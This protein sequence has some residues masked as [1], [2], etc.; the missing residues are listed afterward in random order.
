MTRI[1][2]CFVAMLVS[3]CASSPSIQF[4]ALPA[5]TAA[6]SAVQP[7][8]APL[9]ISVDL[10]AI[11]ELVDRPQMVSRTGGSRVDV[12][13]FHQWAEPLKYAIPRAVSRELAAQLGAGYLVEAGGASGIPAHA[14]V[15]L[16]VQQFD[17]L[18]HQRVLV[19]AVWRIVRRSGDPTI[20][21]SK[22]E[23]A[24]TGAAYTGVA[25]AYG[26]ALATVAK[27][28]A[29]ALVNPGTPAAAKP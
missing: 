8:S 19:D 20:G 12:A 4:Y 29:A 1:A 21:R 9:T 11:P 17:T 10:S 26:R 22:V 23:E 13:E 27:D 25:E 5:T 7:I 2:A 14:R 15:M 16:D 6:P 28:I 18:D 3:A 24:V